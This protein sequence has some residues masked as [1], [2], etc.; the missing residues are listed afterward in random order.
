[1]AKHKCPKCGRPFGNKRHRK[2]N[3]HVYPRGVFGVMGN[4]YQEELCRECHDKLHELI[5]AMEKKILQT[6]KDDYLAI[7]VKF[8]L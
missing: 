7:Y 8:T 2:S 1:M 5:R 4:N 6:H 3:H